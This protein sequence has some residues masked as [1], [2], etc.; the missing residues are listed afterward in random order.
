M[1]IQIQIRRDTAANW[2]SAN[3]TLAQGELGLE[4]DT[5]FLK[6]GNGT[7]VWTLLPYFAS[8]SGGVSSIIAGTGISVNSATGNVTVTN[9]LSSSGGTISGTL[10]V[11]GSVSC[12]ALFNADIDGGSF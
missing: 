12:T 7:N 10:V 11:T 8:S 3:S 4:T 6:I 5:N 9:S 1:A 2:T